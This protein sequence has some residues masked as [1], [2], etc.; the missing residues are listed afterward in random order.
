MSICDLNIFYSL[1]RHLKSY[2]KTSEMKMS[3]EPNGCQYY[4]SKQSNRH[5]T[6]PGKPKDTVPGQWHPWS[7]IRSN[8]PP[9]GGAAPLSPK[10]DIG[11][12]CWSASDT[13]NEDDI[14]FFSSSEH[15]LAPSNYLQPQGLERKTHA[16][17]VFSNW[18]EKTEYITSP[19]NGIPCQEHSRPSPKQPIAVMM[20]DD[21]YNTSD[22]E[23]V[24]VSRPAR[25]SSAPFHLACP[26][27][28]YDPEKCHRCLLTG[29]LRN[30][31]DVIEHLF[32]FHSRP[33][34]CMTC[35]ETFD[36]QTRRDDHVL[37]EKCNE[38]TP[39]PLFGLAESQK[40]TL[41]E[42]GT[43]CTSDKTR[44][45]SIWSIVFPDS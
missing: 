22:D 44:W 27:Y 16:L 15:D 13:E 43:H 31:S 26:F 35:Y 37:H 12:P 21:E 20:T 6:Y 5:S 24:V 28:I 41:L 23:F 42:I 2:F 7:S 11:S 29:E 30:I 4:F 14:G 33:C 36:S 25:R 3:A 8:A 34:Y 1:F 38:R 45:L 17:A 18:K 9:Q 10:H 40:A 32:Q 39:G 19:E